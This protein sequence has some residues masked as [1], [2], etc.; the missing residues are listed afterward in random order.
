[1]KIS[2]I[3]I[4]QPLR[5]DDGIGPEAVR[6]WLK[7]FPAPTSDPFIETVFLETPGLGLLEYLEGADAAILVDAVS[8]GQPAGTVHTPSTLTESPW[9]SGEKS[10][11]GFGVAE[12][13]ALAR[14]TGSRLPDRLLLIGI[15]GTDFT[16][17]SG[18]SEPVRAALPKAAEEIQKA[19]EAWTSGA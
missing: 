15:E 18:L 3:G 5:G 12:S 17:G 4:G 8:S 6:R 14:K 19:V 1:M 2:I 16:M 7:D 10:A 13:I 9:S 11:H